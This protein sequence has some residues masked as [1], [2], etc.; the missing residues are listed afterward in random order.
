MNENIFTN[1]NIHD[2]NQNG[3][4]TIRVRF[5]P[6]PTGLL[7][8]G[9]FRTA[10]F[11][12]LFAGKNNGSFILRIEDTDRKRSKDEFLQS[13]MADMKWMGLNWDE[14]PGVEGKH[15]PY[16]Q[17]QRLETYSQHAQK[18]VEENKAYYCFCKSDDSGSE[19]ESGEDNEKQGK[20]TCSCKNLTKDQ[21]NE[22]KTQGNQACIRFA[23]PSEG[24]ALVRDLIKGD[25]PFDISLIENFVIL[26][27]DGIPTYNF[28]VIVDDHLM[29]ITH[30][31][32]GD[33]HLSNTPRQVL[34]Y[35]AFGYE[36]PVF[37]HIPIILNEDRTKLSKRHGAVH[38]L[39]FRDRGYV[40]E[41][42]LNFMALLGW[43]PK[44]NREILTMEE[45]VEAFSLDGV[46]KHPAVFDEKKLLWMNSQYIMTLPPEIIAERL[47]PFIEKLGFNPSVK[48]ADWYITSVIL[49]RERAKTLVELAENLACFFQET[50]EYDPAGVKKH[51]KPEIL[52]SAMPELIKRVTETDSFTI[53]NL[54]AV[55]RQYAEELG[56]SAG[57]LI[58]PIRLAI[59]GKT[60]SPPVFDVM[61]LAGKEMLKSR[62]QA[63]QSFI[64][65]LAQE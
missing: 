42:L 34:L 59:T 16:F 37:A 30:V 25:V 10:L 26:K 18:L 7:H 48:D 49:Y 20:Q 22:L 45:L 24:E 39:E 12:W 5:A 56:I 4:K 40:K 65:E 57:K 15:S 28:A 6:S 38:L 1:Q 47:A 43:A 2:E 3:E 23:T 60:A 13:Q 41:A 31:I 54:E 46:P 44:D 50:V 53:E 32:R 21:V 63:A 14:G 9:S 36:P 11:N 19:K 52:R 51:F 64:A 33:E 55:V 62:L 17:T 61:V 29:E 58:H 8:V 27:S 35:N